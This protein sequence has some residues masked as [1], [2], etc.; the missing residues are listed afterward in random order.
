MGAV[1]MGKRLVRQA[2]RAAV[3]LRDGNRCRGCGGTRGDLVAHHITDR[4]E[5]P[6]GGYVPENGISLCND[7]HLKAEAFHRDGTAIPGWAPE[8]LY[9]RI[10]SSPEAALAAA[11][12]KSGSRRGSS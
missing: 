10:G 3:F 12:A 4:S 7:C 8:D 11:R 5:M 6:G 9:A 2:F 1:S